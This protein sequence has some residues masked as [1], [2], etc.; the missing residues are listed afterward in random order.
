MTEE[1]LINDLFAHW[2]VMIQIEGIKKLNG[3]A[4]IINNKIISLIADIESYGGKIEPI[5]NDPLIND[6]I[7]T[8]SQGRKFFFQANINTTERDKL[9]AFYGI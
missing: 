4:V 8:D 2:A 9:L 3:K 7:V 6:V 5:K 1:N